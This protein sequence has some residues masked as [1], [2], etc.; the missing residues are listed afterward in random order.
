[1][2]SVIMLKVIMLSVIMS[3]VAMLSIIHDECH[4]AKTLLCLVS[5]KQN[6]LIKLR[7]IMPNVDMLFVLMLN[8]TN[9]GKCHYSKSHYAKYCN[10]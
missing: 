2:M 7:V 9:K 8:V 5:F 6:V 10:A 3:Y 4:Y 1:M